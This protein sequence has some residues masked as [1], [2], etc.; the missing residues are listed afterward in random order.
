MKITILTLFPEMFESYLNNS[1]IKRAQTK[2]LVEFDELE[3]S[4]IFEKFLNIF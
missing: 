3:K 4:E 1:I 2:N